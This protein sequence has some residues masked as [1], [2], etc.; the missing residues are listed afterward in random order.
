MGAAKSHLQQLDRV[1]RKAL[2]ILGPNAVLQSLQARRTV[3]ALAYLFKLMTLQG[4]PQLLALVPPR[5]S[6]PTERRT[7]A[8]HV[9]RHHAQ[10]QL[11]LLP[12]A[13]GLLARSFPYCVIGAWNDLP[14]HLLP[15]N[16]QIKSLQ[17]FK[18]GVHRQ[19]RQQDWL[20]ATDSF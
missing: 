18:V 13:P 12:S 19:L 17:S 16:P 7:R 1:Q 20:W 11:D 5:L 9:A 4:P 10:L 14:V 3:Y 6:P 8:Q 15:A 2:S